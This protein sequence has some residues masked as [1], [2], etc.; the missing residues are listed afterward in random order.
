[1]ANSVRSPNPIL[2][3]L[4]VLSGRTRRNSNA[5]GGERKF[6]VSRVILG[7]ASNLTV[8]RLTD[9]SCGE[10]GRDCRTGDR[11]RGAQ[12]RQPVVPGYVEEPASEE[13]TD[14]TAEAAACLDRPEDRAQVWP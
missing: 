13:R 11:R 7:P 5:F 9:C 1:M 3:S 12:E 4:S 2:A 14:C 8:L 6:Y 10:P